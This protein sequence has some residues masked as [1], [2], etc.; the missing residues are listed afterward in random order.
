MLRLPDVTV[1]EDWHIYLNCSLLVLVDHSQHLLA[2]GQLTSQVVSMALYAW[3]IVKTGKNDLLMNPGFRFAH[4]WR[5][6]CELLL[7]KKGTIPQSN[8]TLSQ[9]NFYIK[10][11][12]KYLIS[13]SVKDFDSKYYLKSTQ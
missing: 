7:N 4:C 3:G 12:Q 9:V 13:L 1:S 6:Y 8:S 10:F 2:D 11:G 5:K